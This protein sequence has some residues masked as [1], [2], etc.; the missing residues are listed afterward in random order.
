VPA[1]RWALGYGDITRQIAH[2]VEQ[3]K[4][5]ILVVGSHGHKGLSDLLHGTTITGVRHALTIP[6]LAV[7]G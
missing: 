4:V 5:D 1:V 6:V 2:L 3:E 7:R